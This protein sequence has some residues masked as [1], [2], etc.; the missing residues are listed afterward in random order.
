MEHCVNENVSANV[1]KGVRKVNFK[2]KLK[3]LTVAALVAVIFAFPLFIGCDSLS[4]TPPD[5]TINS[6]DTG[7]GQ[8]DETPTAETFDVAFLSNGGTEV[9]SQTVEK[10][11][12]VV[13][14]AD[15][16]KA[17]HKF[18]GWYFGETE[19]DFENMTVNKD[20]VLEAR[21]ES[22]YTKPYLPED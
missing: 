8:K 10:N 11:C 18:V 15:P 19:W 3:I 17:E 22:G 5:N 21:W 13:K 2:Q 20:T 16:E 6:G 12:K 14:P 1:K 4:E 7:S 9:P